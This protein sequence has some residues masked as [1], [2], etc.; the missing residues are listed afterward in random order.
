MNIMEKTPAMLNIRIDGMTWEEVRDMIEER[1]GALMW[2]NGV[3]YPTG[4]VSISMTFA[5]PA[6]AVAVRAAKGQKGQA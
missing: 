3:A 2:S 6:S 5:E 1:F 4:T